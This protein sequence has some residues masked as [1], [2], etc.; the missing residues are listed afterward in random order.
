MRFPRLLYLLIMAFM[1]LTVL[2]SDKAGVGEV[3]NSTEQVNVLGLP[4][5]YNWTPLALPGET[6]AQFVPMI[7]DET[8][9]TPEVLD[10]VK[11]HSGSPF[12]LGFNEPERHDQADM[13][14]EAALALW[15][16]LE[17]TGKTLGSPAVSLDKK[18]KEWLREFMSRADERKLR[19]DFICVH[20]YG[21]I[22]KP[23]AVGSLKD[24]LDSLHEAYDRP[25]WLTEFGAMDFYFTED[26]D[27]PGITA[28]FIREA[29]PMLESLPYLHRYA[30]FTTLPYV[31]YDASALFLAAGKDLTKVGEAYRAAT[32]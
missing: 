31:G 11:T 17:A 20:W 26:A 29:I 9:V 22:T 18:G 16:Q 19:V 21:D 6:T 23:G 32:E 3:H 25:I 2:A 28:Q 30:W 8:S 15:P 5:Y 4:W 7:W 12:L 14:V 1:P 27:R 13:T 10:R 24:V